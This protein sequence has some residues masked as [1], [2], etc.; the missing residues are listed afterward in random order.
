M[1]TSKSVLG[2]I[3]QYLTLTI[4]GALPF[5]SGCGYKNV[6][7]DPEFKQELRNMQTGV[8]EKA[9]KVAELVKK[10]GFEDVNRY[11]C[12][13]DPSKY[14]VIIGEGLIYSKFILVNDSRRLELNCSPKDPT[15]RFEG[16]TI[17]VEDKLND[18]TRFKYEF[19]DSGLDS[20]DEYSEDFYAPF[21]KIPDSL[22]RRLR[23][24]KTEEQK[25]DIEREK[26]RRYI[27]ILD[28]TLEKLLL[29]D[30]ALKGK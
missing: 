4:A 19:Y 14:T 15:R 17:C 24:A 30:K 29:E 12:F 28:L 22:V 10:Y 8:P 13:E 2:R 3:G 1:R 7:D 20:L 6:M 18:G 23:H 11:Y 27:A 5:A 26:S 25:K 9:R 16:L 21:E